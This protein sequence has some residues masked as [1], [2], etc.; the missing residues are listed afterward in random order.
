MDGSLVVGGGRGRLR[1]RIKTRRAGSCKSNATSHDGARYFATFASDY[2]PIVRLRREDW[3]HIVF[4]LLR[5]ALGEP[6]AW[7]P[8]LARRLSA[9]PRWPPPSLARGIGPETAPGGAPTLQRA[10]TLTLRSAPSR[11][12]RRAVAVSS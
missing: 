9:G 4:V 3:C 2:V 11:K 5:D 6:P 10:R 1:E 8:T 12:T 7:V